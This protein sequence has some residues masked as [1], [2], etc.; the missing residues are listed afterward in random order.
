MRLCSPVVRLFCYIAEDCVLLNVK[1]QYDV[2][3]F[4]KINLLLTCMPCH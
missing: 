2:Y 3:K 1:V 4:A